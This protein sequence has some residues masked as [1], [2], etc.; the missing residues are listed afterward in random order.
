MA[1]LSEI[2]KIDFTKKSLDN[3]NYTKLSQKFI[4]NIICNNWYEKFTNSRGRPD[5]SLMSLSTKKGP[6]ICTKKGPLISKIFSS[7]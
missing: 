7:Q 5:L 3:I 4:G 6:L 1:Y 2:K